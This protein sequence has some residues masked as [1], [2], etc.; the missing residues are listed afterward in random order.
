MTRNPGT[1]VQ[2][3][4]GTREP[5]NY[6]FA[7]VVRATTKG[8][9]YFSSSEEFGYVIRYD[10]GSEV[11]KSDYDVL[12][13]YPMMARKLREGDLLRIGSS[14]DY[15]VLVA[16]VA[17][18]GGRIYVTA[19]DGDRPNAAGCTHAFDVDEPVVLNGRNLGP[20]DMIAHV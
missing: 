9:V 14:R 15:H 6:P 11:W 18:L 13:V 8:E 3:H 7:T 16:E 12:D 5:A 10:N 4:D 2:I 20:S 17:E 1:R 19:Y